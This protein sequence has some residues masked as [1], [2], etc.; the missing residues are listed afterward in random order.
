VQAGDVTIAGVDA[1]P[2]DQ[3]VR[4][5]YVETALQVRGIGRSL[6]EAALEHPRLAS[7]PRAP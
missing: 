7:A 4:R 6:L 2:G 1:Q 5:L 3:S